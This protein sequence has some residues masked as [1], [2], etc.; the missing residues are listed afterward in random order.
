MA[1][2][3]IILPAWWRRNSTSRTLQAA[4]PLTITN[5]FV[6]LFQSLLRSTVSTTARSIDV[7]PLFPSELQRECMPALVLMRK[8][9]HLLCVQCDVSFHRY[10]EYSHIAWCRMERNLII[11]RL[12]I[13]CR[14][15]E[16]LREIFREFVG[17]R[18]HSRFLNSHAIQD[19]ISLINSH[20]PLLFCR[21]K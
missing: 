4:L 21:M 18:G 9:L 13:D 8:E 15:D 12:I 20:D 17:W 10:G 14:D 19:Y 1:C 7:A 16:M 11:S 3:F 5:S 2:I 6:S